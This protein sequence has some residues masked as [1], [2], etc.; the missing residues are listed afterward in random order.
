MAAAIHQRP[1]AEYGLH[2]HSRRQDSNLRQS[3]FTPA[4]AAC[5]RRHD[6]PADMDRPKHHASQDGDAR[7]HGSWWHIKNAAGFAESARHRPDL[8]Q[9]VPVK[10]KVS[11]R[12]SGHVQDYS[13]TPG[14]QLSHA[15]RR[16]VG[17]HLEL[18]CQWLITSTNCGCSMSSTAT[19]SAEHRKPFSPQVGL[20]RAA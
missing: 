16:I 4:D 19:P 8:G 17:H 18:L 11:I 15:G 5:I 13:T 7:R 2:R 14:R 3:L 20:C 12:F 6:R 9:V 1:V 10:R